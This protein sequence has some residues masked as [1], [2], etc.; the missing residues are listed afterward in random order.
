MYGLKKKLRRLSAL[1]IIYIYSYSCRPLLTATQS[2]SDYVG[3]RVLVDSVFNLTQVDLFFSFAW[4][5][6]DVASITRPVTVV[7]LHV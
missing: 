1:P 2:A 5:K 6:F 3:L 4:L 7:Y